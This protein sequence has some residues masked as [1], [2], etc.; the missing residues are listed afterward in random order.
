M[1]NILE[2]K[3]LT[4]TYDSFKLDNLSFS[5]K[6]GYI[7]GF[8]GPNGAGKSTTIKLI[9]NLVKKDSGTIELFGK[10]YQKYEKSVKE[11]IGFIYDQNHYYDDLTIA[12]MKRIIA[13]YYPAWNET[14]FNGYIKRFNLNPNKKIKEL[15]RGM[16]TKFSLAIALSHGAELI[17]MDEPTSGLDPI[18]RSEILDILSEIIEE[19]NCSVLFS[20]HITQDLERAADYIT[21]INEGKLIF[22]KEKDA[23]LE[24]YALIKGPND[25]LKDPHAFKGLVGYRRGKYGFSALFE[26]THAL[27]DLDREK[28]V[29][30]RP[31]IDDIMLYTVRG[32]SND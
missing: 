15:S 31:N 3:N 24:D 10:D 5:L 20:S 19:G 16:K 13:P 2:V 23:I 17:I 9:M 26:K 28:I 18:F 14:I 25:L 27:D 11:R 32:N 8:I 30:E 12:R 6:K 29:I 22:S 1:E 7:M 4:K 21:F